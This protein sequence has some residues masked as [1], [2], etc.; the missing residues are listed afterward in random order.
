MS[1]ITQFTKSFLVD[2]D[3]AALAEYVGLFLV[4]A[5]AGMAGMI[6]LG[7]SIDSI[8][9]QMSDWLDLIPIPTSLTTT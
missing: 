6:A 7:N 3:G 8:F 2:E 5:I 4:M 9:G 1:K